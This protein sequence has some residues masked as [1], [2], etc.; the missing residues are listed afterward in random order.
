MTGEVG[1]AADR[2]AVARNPDRISAVLE[3]GDRVGAVEPGEVE[4][5]GAGA[6]Y[7]RVIALPAVQHV[8][9]VAAVQDESHGGCRYRRRVDHV[10]AGEAMDGERMRGA[11]GVA[12]P[13][14]G[15]MVIWSSPLV[16][17]NP[18]RESA[19][20]VNAVTLAPVESDG[21]AD[22]GDATMLWMT[23]LSPGPPSRTS[24][25][26]AADQH[27]VSGAAAQDVLAGAADQ[28]SSP[29]PPSAVSTSP[30]RAPRPRSR[31]RRPGR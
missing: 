29:S 21:P 23:M 28:T 9:A 20:I 30:C 10:V 6:A 11:A 14:G 12:A 13:G 19:C 5:V 4:A 8:V 18:V 24:L 25:P 17:S 22:G 1:E 2:R 27:I 7:H 3:V 16:P 31:R 15:V 26:A